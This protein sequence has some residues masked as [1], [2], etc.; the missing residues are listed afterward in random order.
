MRTRV[1]LGDALEEIID[2]R[3]KTPKKLG[4]DWSP[5]G[6][7]VLSAINIKNN[8]I[9]TNDHHYVSD[10]LYARWMR[11][12]L[13]AGDVLLT[14]E[15]PLGE[16]AY[17][18]RDVDW[19][20][21]QRLFGLRGRPGLLDGRYLSYAL[22]GGSVRDELLSRS[23][24]STVAGIRQAE[25]VKVEIDLPSIDE[26]RQVATQ[27]GDLDD[28]ID[29]NQ[30]QLT[31]LDG[32]FQIRWKLASERAAE[33]RR[34]ADIVSTQ[35]GLT[36][37]AIHGSDGPRFLRVTDINKENWVTWASTPAVDIDDAELEKYKL[38][39]GDLVVARMADPGKAAIYDDPN[40][41]AVFASYLVRLKA[42]SYSEALY[43]YGFLKSDLYA[44]YA[45]GATTGSVQKNM[46]A[47]VIVDV[48]LP[49]PTPADLAEFA[50]VAT[51]L[52]DGINQKVSE[53]VRLSDLRETLLPEL[54]SGRSP[55]Q[56]G[57]ASIEDDS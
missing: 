29:S 7:R 31:L 19:C 50:A 24:G 1:A 48:E 46:N 3:G 12:P 37:S 40:V 15:A 30:R 4:G 44:E 2:H 43:I 47:R 52:R 14:S 6:H 10:E 49:W 18:D 34:L 32:L 9:D 8:R 53:N 54:L 51:G 25:L 5:T 41:S 35:Y 28:K 11:V 57:F 42:Q 45:A 39:R 38:H 21:G 27:L 17:L 16:V 22:R 56:K 33:R 23:T 13:R 20:L 36:A 55:R 26:Q